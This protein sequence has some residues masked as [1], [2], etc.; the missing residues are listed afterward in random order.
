[1]ESEKITSL[2]IFFRDGAAPWELA[3]DPPCH[4]LILLA[5]R[6]V[7]ATVTCAHPSGS[8]SL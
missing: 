6:P 2:S 8:A 4:N 1:M 5:H 3:S 7:T